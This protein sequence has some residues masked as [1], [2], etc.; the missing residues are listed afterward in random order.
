[1]TFMV[2]NDDGIT[3][4][5]LSPVEAR[6]KVAHRFRDAART[7]KQ[8][9]A[10]P[11]LRKYLRSEPTAFQRQAYRKNL[12]LSF[13]G[14]CLQVQGR[15]ELK[16]TLLLSAPLNKEKPVIT[17]SS[18]KNIALSLS[19]CIRRPFSESTNYTNKKRKRYL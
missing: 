7:A 2:I 3:L 1:M 8:V 13:D 17:T 12:S 16:Q 6:K 14:P 10:I 4:K 5:E 19:H 9:D 15:T 11:K 18:S